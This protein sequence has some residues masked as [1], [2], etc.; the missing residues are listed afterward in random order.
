MIVHHYIDIEVPSMTYTIGEISKMFQIPI[1][2]IRYYDSEGLFPFIKRDEHD[3]RYFEE[4]DLKLIRSII[5]LKETNMPLK[6]IKN[7]IHLYMDGN[8]TLEKRYQIFYAHKE[9]LLQQIKNL[10]DSM[11][12]MD[13]T[14]H[15]YSKAIEDYYQSEEC[16]LKENPSL[17]EDYQKTDPDKSSYHPINERVNTSLINLISENVEIAK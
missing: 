15:N 4:K 7:Y 13:K 1:H 16:T 9:K 12:I 5:C 3:N 17:S 10:E 8:S 14:M 6:E 2:T 11:A